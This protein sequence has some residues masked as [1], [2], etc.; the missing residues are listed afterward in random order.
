[1]ANPAL[2]SIRDKEALAKL[3]EADRAAFVKYWA[4]VDALLAK[5]DKGK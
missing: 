4:D 2:A 3:S 5:L 1:M